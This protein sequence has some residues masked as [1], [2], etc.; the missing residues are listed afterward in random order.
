[1]NL[2]LATLEAIR[3][4]VLKT[5]YSTIVYNVETTCNNNPEKPGILSARENG[6]V[7]GDIAY[8]VLIFSRAL[9]LKS[10][11]SSSLTLVKMSWNFSKSTNR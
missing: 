1:V 3:I 4:R 6:D 2:T 8:A 11:R 5:A 9:F 7:A 10:M